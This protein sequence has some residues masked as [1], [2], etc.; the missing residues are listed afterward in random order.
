M[1]R[2]TY[3]DLNQ[4]MGDK[5]EESVLPLRKCFVVTSSELPRNNAIAVKS[6]GEVDSHL[7]DEDFTKTVFFI[8]GERIYRKGIAKCQTAYVTIVNKDVNADRHFPVKYLQKHF[9]MTKLLSV[10]GEAGLRFT[11]WNRK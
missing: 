10:D 5:G 11:I 6:I 3:D 9:T 2:T 7:T 8:G 4:R 1:G